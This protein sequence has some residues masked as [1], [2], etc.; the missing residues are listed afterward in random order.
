MDLFQNLVMNAPA[1]SQKTGVPQDKVRSISSSLQAKL[2]GHMGLMDAV[3][4]TAK[5]HDI[6][7]DQ[8]HEI[9]TL[10]GPGDDPT[11]KLGSLFS[12]LIKRQ[13]L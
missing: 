6:P 11:G 9:L 2:E 4:A 5:E 1:I 3:E 8:F 7:L 10:A 13:T 12:G